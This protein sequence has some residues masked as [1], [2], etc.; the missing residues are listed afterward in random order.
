MVKILLVYLGV[1]KLCFVSAAK[2][3]A[4]Q[5][6]GGSTSLAGDFN[7]EKLNNWGLLEDSSSIKL[8]YFDVIIKIQ[9]ISLFCFFQNSGSMFL[10]TCREDKKYSGC[11]KFSHPQ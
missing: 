8:N 7:S 11:S 4:L 1:R 6:W 3:E 10:F 5:V 2:P 9:A